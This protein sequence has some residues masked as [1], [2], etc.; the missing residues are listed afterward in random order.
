[1]AEALKRAGGQTSGPDIKAAME[2]L[3]DFDPMGLT[4]PISYFPGDHRPNM[5]VMLFTIQNGKFKELAKQSLERKKE[6]L[7]N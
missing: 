1:M 6:W 7:G 3:R 2:T 5:T 4:P